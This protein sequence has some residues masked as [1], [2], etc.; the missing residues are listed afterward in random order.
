MELKS[1][2]FEIAAPPPAAVDDLPP[3]AA[4]VKRTDER[5]KLKAGRT[6]LLPK[7]TGKPRPLREPSVFTKAA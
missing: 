6:A 7:P 4:D 3:K 1:A 2:F 5:F